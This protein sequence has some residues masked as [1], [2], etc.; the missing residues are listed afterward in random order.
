MKTTLVRVALACLA[1]TLST[2]AAMADPV[3]GVNVWVGPIILEKQTDANGQITLKNLAP[4]NYV[5]KIDGKSLVAA[6]DRFAP[7]TP[8]KS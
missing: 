4:G 6:M 2:T 8:A 3:P 5:I 1:L 7:P